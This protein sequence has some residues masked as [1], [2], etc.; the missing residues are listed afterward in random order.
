M[1]DSK[2]SR[3]LLAVPDILLPLPT[4]VTLFEYKLHRALRKHKCR[5]YDRHRL[6]AEI[7]VK[8]YLVES[9]ITP[10]VNFRFW[11]LHGIG[12]LIGTTPLYYIP[13]LEM[14]KPIVRSD[15]ENRKNKLRQQVAAVQRHAKR[16]SYGYP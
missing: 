12:V 7:R 15:R 14:A 13:T 6:A 16:K 2:K 8:R 11:Y 4:D 5:W 9:R 3:N 10:T 1:K